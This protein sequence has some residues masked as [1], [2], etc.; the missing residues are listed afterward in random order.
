MGGS[1]ILVVGATG[2]LGGDVARAL[3]DAGHQLFCTG[4]NQP[5]L[6]RLAREVPGISPRL[7]E[8]TDR[9]ATRHLIGEINRE[10]GLAAYVHLAGGFAM[11]SSVDQL[12]DEDWDAMF[13]MNWVGL[14][15]GASA[16]F[17]VLRHRGG[18]SIVT[19]GSLA[20]F[21]GGASMAPYAVSKA[22]VVAFTRC[23]A[24]EGKQLGIR[25]N[26]IVPGILDTPGNRR[27]MPDA[28]RVGWVPTTQVAST[29]AFLCSPGS[30]SVNGTTLMMKGRL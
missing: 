1:A 22:A 25:A 3:R 4:R 20:A 21:S 19:V 23:L 28:D 26:C 27:A 24:E 30:A 2:G 16:A 5:A 29:V 13:S 12:A 15:V 11:G 10:H 9:E 18:G 8:A 14:R 6:D 17:G 7:L